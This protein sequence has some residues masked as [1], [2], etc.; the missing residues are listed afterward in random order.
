M[1]NIE[2]FRDG[3]IAAIISKIEAMERTDLIRELVNL[4]TLPVLSMTTRQLLAYR[5]K[6]VEE[7]VQKYEYIN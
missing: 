3:V 1:N 2:D 5:K 4:K 7:D 6:M